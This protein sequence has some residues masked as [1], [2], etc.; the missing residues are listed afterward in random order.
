MAEDA[1]VSLPR[2]MVA[3]I[4]AAPWPAP[5]GVGQPGVGLGEQELRRAM[6]ED[7]IEV[8][9]GLDVVET[10]LL[11]TDDYVSMCVNVRCC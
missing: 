1:A 11:I 6:T 8:V 4:P 9:S 10:S 5:G 2:R 7:V 3:V